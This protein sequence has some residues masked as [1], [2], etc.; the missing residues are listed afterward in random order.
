MESTWLLRTL[1][2][3][4]GDLERPLFSLQMVFPAYLIPARF[5]T[6]PRDLNGET[7]A[8]SFQ[9]TPVLQSK[10]LRQAHQVSQFSFFTWVELISL[11]VRPSLLPC[12]AN[13]ELTTPS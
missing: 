4:F 11:R 7:V 5:I 13:E 1:P 6:F 2:V 9:T 10:K 3:S 12:G 8:S